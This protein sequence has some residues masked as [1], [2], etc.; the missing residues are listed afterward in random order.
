MVTNKHLYACFT[1]ELSRV[2]VTCYFNIEYKRT[3]WPLF[4]CIHRQMKPFTLTQLMKSIFLTCP[5]VSGILLLLLQFM[6][7][8]N[9][10]PLVVI[11]ADIQETFRH[12]LQNTLSLTPNNRQTLMLP[13]EVTRFPRDWSKSHHLLSL[14]ESYCNW[15]RGMKKAKNMLWKRARY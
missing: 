10:T 5:V 13:W 12:S 14:M 15:K 8:Q 6:A 4:V 11:L 2:E 3:H 9:W 1:Q 7:K